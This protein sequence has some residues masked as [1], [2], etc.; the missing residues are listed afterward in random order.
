M[1]GKEPWAIVNMTMSCQPAKRAPEPTPELPRSR[2]LKKRTPKLR[3]IYDFRF[4][5]AGPR[6]IES[7]IVEVTPQ[8]RVDLSYP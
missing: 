5:E 6:K 2:S 4:L 3:K 8:Y 1:E 7:D